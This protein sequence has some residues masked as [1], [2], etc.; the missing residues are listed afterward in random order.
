MK[1]ATAKGKGMKDMGVIRQQIS[2]TDQDD[3]DCLGRQEV[4]NCHMS[5]TV[6]QG[7]KCG[8]VGGG[9]EKAVY[10]MKGLPFFTPKL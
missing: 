9:M 3:E 1:L 10:Y 6:G 4:G 7:A 5:G 8:L 2:A